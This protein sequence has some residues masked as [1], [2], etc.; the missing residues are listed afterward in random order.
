MSDHE[1][2]KVEEVQP[3]SKN[4]QKRLIRAAEREAT[5][6]EWRHAKKQKQKENRQKRLAQLKESLGDDSKEVGALLD[7][8]RH[9]IVPV[10]KQDQP[11]HT[12]LVDMSFES[13]MSER[14]CSS[15]CSQLIR[16]YSVNR[17]TT[18]P[19]AVTV[20]GVDLE[21]GVGMG[22]IMKKKFPDCSRW[23][24]VSIKKD[25]LDKIVEGV[26]EEDRG[27]FI[28]LTADSEVSLSD[29]PEI[30]S[31]ESK[32]TFIIGGIVDRNRLKGTT[33]E[34]AKELGI[35]TAKLPLADFI[36][37]KSSTVLSVVHGTHPFFTI[38]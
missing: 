35:R 11:Q 26:S 10:D 16:C 34:R 21:K 31:D 28:Y 12:V 17:R 7:P 27:Q 24:H 32:L 33:L 14:E 20:A 1:N 29:I 23:S 38:F 8:G 18:K 37:L 25:T 19:L 3:L 2:D 13:I 4:Q 30:Q 36:D 5:K 22:S 6:S 15:M 9:S